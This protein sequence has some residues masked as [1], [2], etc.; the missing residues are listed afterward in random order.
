[1]SVFDAAA[2]LACGCSVSAISRVHFLC[3]GGVM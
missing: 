2:F 3:C 1:M